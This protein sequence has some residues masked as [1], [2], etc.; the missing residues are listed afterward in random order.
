MKYYMGVQ[1]AV[2]QTL[3]FGWS[4]H[5]PRASVQ[6]RSCAYMASTG[7]TMQNHTSSEGPFL[8]PRIIRTQIDGEPTNAA[9]RYLGPV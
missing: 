4:S 3:P 5:F 7:P 1:E 8:R 2:H 6:V 9:R